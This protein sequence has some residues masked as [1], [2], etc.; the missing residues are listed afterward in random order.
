M[1]IWDYSFALRRATLLRLALYRIIWMKR[2]GREQASLRFMSCMIGP[3]EKEVRPRS[4]RQVLTLFFAVEVQE[5]FSM[6][7]LSC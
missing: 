2:V 1:K 3:F 6:K 7:F 4:Y 5:I